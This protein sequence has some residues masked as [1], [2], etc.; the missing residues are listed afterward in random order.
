MARR[1]KRSND[2]SDEEWEVERICARRL[3][4]RHRGFEYLIKWHGWPESSNTWEPAAHLGHCAEMRERFD[5]SQEKD[6]AADLLPSSSASVPLKKR[7]RKGEK[8]QNSTAEDDRGE[9]GAALE[10]SAA[11]ASPAA[12]AHVGHPQSRHQRTALN[13]G[14]EAVAEADG[15]GQDLPAEDEAHGQGRRRLS[16]ASRRAPNLLAGDT[17]LGP[18]GE[19]G[20]SDSD[21]SRVSSA[22]SASSAGSVIRRRAKRGGAVRG[23]V[24]WEAEVDSRPVL[25]IGLLGRLEDGT[26]S[27]DAVQLG[28]S[29]FAVNDCVRMAAEGGTA[30]WVAR[31]VRIL[32]PAGRHD[33]GRVEVAWFYS[34]E[35]VDVAPEEQPR[36]LTRGEIWEG[37]I[38]GE[39][40]VE[41]QPLGAVIGRAAV[42]TVPYWRAYKER[43]LALEPDLVAQPRP[44]AALTEKKARDAVY[45]CR[46]VWDEG[47]QRVT[48][49]V[50]C[51]SSLNR[52]V[53]LKEGPSGKREEPAPAPVLDE[54]APA[55]G[56]AGPSASSLPSPPPPPL[57][58]DA[59]SSN[60]PAPP[61]SAPPLASGAATPANSTSK[62]AGPAA[63][64]PD[65]L[66]QEAAASAPVASDAP[67][68][69][70]KKRERGP[71]PPDAVPGKPPG[72]TQTLLPSSSA[73]TAR[74]APSHAARP[75]PGHAL[76]AAPPAGPAHGSGLGG[77]AQAQPAA[78]VPSQLPGGGPS[79]SG[80]GAPGAP[81]PRPFINLKIRVVDRPLVPSSAPKHP[82]ASPS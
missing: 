10:S 73:P 53:I 12:D 42:L 82:S 52:G 71:Q 69:R 62:C 46:R 68:A 14:F 49:R 74:P 72:N 57:P 70:R 78:K 63:E 66:R 2:S 20:G 60:Q 3:S 40:H 26:E 51:L 81:A 41:T 7:F 54:P 23:A 47:Q 29:R 1:R 43:R 22:A 21:E 64:P 19:P 32:M 15:A 79:A 31:V 33:E 13:A 34:R 8:L 75:P 45:L 11:P 18:S 30:L 61:P 9:A 80:A 37:M 16:L 58:T 59:A 25:P 76:H 48:G 55:P 5:R 28:E 24:A 50:R 27:Y 6:S 35:H 77:G 39:P 38:D 44:P 67:Q 65:G 17:S 56:C 4:H 36:P